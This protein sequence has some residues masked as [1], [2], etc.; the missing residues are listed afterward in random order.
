ML[1]A[2]NAAEILQERRQQEATARQD[3]RKRGQRYRG[4]YALKI[5]GLPCCGPGRSAKIELEPSNAARNREDRRQHVYHKEAV[6]SVHPQLV[7]DQPRHVKIAPGGDSFRH[8]HRG[9]QNTF[10]D[11]GP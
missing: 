7:A 3:H 6:A 9:T 10:T 5:G 8:I 2:G 4:G 1:A 11:G